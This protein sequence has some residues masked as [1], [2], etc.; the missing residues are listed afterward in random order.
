MTSQSFNYRTF[1]KERLDERLARNENLTL[2]G[3]ALRIGISP[4]MLSEVLSGKKN[5]SSAKSLQLAEK[6]NL[7]PSDSERLLLMVQ[8]ETARDHRVR[9][10]YLNRLCELETSHPRR[11]FEVDQFRFISDWYHLAILQLPLLNG[12]ELTVDSAVQRLGITPVQADGALQ[13][14]ARLKLLESKPDGTFTRTAESFLCETAV[15]DQAFGSF[16]RAMLERA[17]EALVEQSPRERLSGGEMIPLDPSLLPEAKRILDRAL[18]QIAE[19]GNQS[20]Q[21]RKHVYYYSSQF[22]R[23]DHPTRK[24]NA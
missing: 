11:P 8:I 6:L 16:Y 15:H 24:G 9:A 10:T 23:V 13:R 17:G 21:S 18:D 20:P 5:L 12:F 4:S 2:R 19:L 14:L 22:F 3:L 7:S 1:L